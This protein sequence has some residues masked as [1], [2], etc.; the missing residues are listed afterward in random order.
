MIVKADLHIH[1]TYS[2][3][4][5]SPRE[6]INYGYFY[7]G[8]K[9]ISITDHDT[10]RGST[11]A[12]KFLRK[13][14]YEI[15]LVIGAEIKTDRGD[16]LLYCMDEVNAPRNL[17]KLID[18]AHENSCIV[19]PAH[20]FDILRLGVGELI[21]EYK[22]DAV[23]VWNASANKGANLKAIKAA[24]QMGLPALANSDAH[25]ADEIAVAH[26]ELELEEL[27][28]DSFVKA[29]RKGYVKPVYGSTNFRLKAKRILFSAKRFLTR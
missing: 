10:F 8:L 9:V 6:I 14:G 11:E 20:P 13:A 4:A 27:S 1:S 3:G 28:F 15:L 5:N 2:D 18:Y 29:V 22:W 17:D 21:Y 12:V 7:K 26:T 23:E 24:K 16:I 19:V 25:I